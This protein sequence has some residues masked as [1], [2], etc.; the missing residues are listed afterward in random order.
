MPESNTQTNKQPDPVIEPEPE[1]EPIGV[2]VSI[3]HSIE[4]SEDR[5]REI[6]TAILKDH[7][8]SHGEI[9]I[10]VVDDPTI[11]ELNRQY[12]DHDYGT[13]VLSFVLEKN[14]Q[15]RLLVGEVIISADTAQTSGDEVG[16]D[17][18]DELLLYL[19]HGMLHLVGFDDKD[20]AKREAMR[21]AEQDYT[22]RFGISYSCPDDQDD[23]G[24]S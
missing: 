20:P 16:V 5:I 17:V 23:G 14:E 18:V 15:Q 11:H 4:L 21:E 6:C 3:Q 2:D 19:I 22:S 10:A 13:D 7:D 1:P 24:Q 12:L 9:S 8:W